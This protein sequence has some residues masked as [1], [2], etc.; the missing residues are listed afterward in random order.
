MTNNATVNV[1]TGAAF[2]VPSLLGLG[3]RAPYMHDGCA[4]TVRDCLGACGGGE[5]HGH[6][7]QLTRSEL[8]D[9]VAWLESL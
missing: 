6:T 8:H 7:A 5:R 1:G 3:R 4:T 2:Q 9:L